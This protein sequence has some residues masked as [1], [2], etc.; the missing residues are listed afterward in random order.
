[1]TIL[2]DSL[3][4]YDGA[5]VAAPAK[6]HGRRWCHMVSDR[7]FEELHEFAQRLGLRRSWFQRDHY[8][9]TPGM[10]AK[11]VRFGAEEVTLHELGRRW[12]NEVTCKECGDVSFR[13]RLTSPCPQCGFV[14]LDNL[15]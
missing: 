8:D 9:L 13:N 4:D 6:K 7:S 14:L 10:R 11:A 1:M 5:L 3:T 12:G 15:T 2:V